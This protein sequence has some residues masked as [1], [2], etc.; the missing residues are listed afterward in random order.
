MVSGWTIL[1]SLVWVSVG[2]V[3]GLLAAA[4]MV[5]AKRD[6]EDTEDGDE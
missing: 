5:G 6:E 2:V 1:A 4:L 3:I